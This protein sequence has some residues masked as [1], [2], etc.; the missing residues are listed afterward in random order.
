MKSLTRSYYITYE[1][2]LYAETLAEFWRDFKVVLSSDP[3][4]TYRLLDPRGIM[5]YPEEA[6][7]GYQ[8][9]GENKTNMLLYLMKMNTKHCRYSREAFQEFLRTSGEFYDQFYKK[10]NELRK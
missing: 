8:L 7:V 5:K 2:I 10:W 6:V 3:Q 4:L 1:T 9:Q